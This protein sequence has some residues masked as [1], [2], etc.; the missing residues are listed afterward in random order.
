MGNLQA[1]DTSESRNVKNDGD[2]VSL[3]LRVPKKEVEKLIQCSK[4]ESEV[5]E[6]I[7]EL[8]MAN[9]GGKDSKHEIEEIGEKMMVQ[10][11]IMM[12]RKH[13]IVGERFKGTRG[14]RC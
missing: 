2:G 4:N 3:K 8:Y 9:N 13:D 11:Q 10:E 12:H 7:I 1:K 14:A 6:R 5:V